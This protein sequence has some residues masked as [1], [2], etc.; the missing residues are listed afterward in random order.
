[1]SGETGRLHRGRLPLSSALE[2]HATACHAPAVLFLRLLLV[3]AALST[4]SGCAFFYGHS[5]FQRYHLVRVTDIR[6]ELVAEWV[7]EGFVARTER[8]YRF[9]AVERLSGGRYREEIHY[10]LGRQIEIG[11][12]NIVVA[13]TGKP[14][15]LY[16]LEGR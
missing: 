10:P 9:K 15:W 13:R 2:V 6:G 1:M 12:Q 11:G 4:L 7:A 16:Q 14:L 3:C 8:G 5:P